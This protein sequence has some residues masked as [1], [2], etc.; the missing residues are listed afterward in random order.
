MKLIEV[1]KAFAT[2]EKCLDYLE[3]SRWPDGVRCTTCGSKEISKITRKV[4]AKTDNKRAR[5]YQCLEPTCKAQFSATTGTIF[6]GSHLPLEK[7]YMAIALIIDAKKGMSSLQL[8]RHLK[9]NYRTA[10]Y[11]S[12]RIREAMNEPDGLKL[13]GTVEIDETYIGGKQKGNK[14]K[15]LNKDV[16]LGIRQRGGPLRLVHV[17]DA[18]QGTLYDAIAPH[19]DRN[20][21]KIMTDDAGAYDFRFTQ[22]HKIPHSK[23]R[24]SRKEYVRGEVH[25][26]TVE[27]AFSLLKRAVIG[28]YH[29]LSIKHLQRYLNEFSYRFN[30]REDAEMFEKLV[31][32]MVGE[33]P[34]PYSKLIEQNAFTPFVRPTNRGA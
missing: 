8:Q 13:T 17:K 25:T 5:L 32:R 21:S 11:L 33:K 16:V 29:Q 23:I 6:N 31:A 22:F 4:T 3:A 18:K 19:L 24:H 14:R 20:A 1:T 26:N 12:H 2:E 7:W 27:N 30:R 10:W 9:V 34:M 15:R 28:T